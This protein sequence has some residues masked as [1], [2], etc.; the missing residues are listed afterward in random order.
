MHRGAAAL[1]AAAAIAVGALPATTAAF[2]HTSSS[3]ASLAAGAVAAATGFTATRSCTPV[4]SAITLRGSSSA[5]DHNGD[6]SLLVPVP[7]HVAGDL[8]LAHVAWKYNNHTISPPAGW[9]LVRQDQYASGSLVSGVFR[10]TATSSEPASYTWPTE[11]G[12]RAAGTIMAWTGTDP[13]AA[14]SAHAGTSAV[15]STTMTMP[16]VTA[17][18]SGSRL[19]AIAAQRHE[20][21]ITPP[22]GMTELSDLTTAGG[23]APDRDVNAAIS[24][25]VVEAGPTGVRTASPTVA[26]PTDTT[27]QAVLL[28][29]LMVPGP[30]DAALSWTATSDTASSGY[31]LRRYSGGVLQ[32]STSVTPRTTSSLLVG[33][34]VAGTAYSWE[35]TTLRGN[36]RS[37]A[38]TA[39]LTPTAC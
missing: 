4:P 7:T 23:G 39:A 19:L 30:P 9:T 22:V 21:S 3:T 38:A 6:G 33:P 35:L 37:A 11:G 25:E 10:R 15:T 34:L 2:S 20:G 31:E 13:A 32:A 16:S 18:R 12:E 5:L 28:N 29:P 27:G 8:L 14:I 36:W 26:N 17:A 24:T 1:Y